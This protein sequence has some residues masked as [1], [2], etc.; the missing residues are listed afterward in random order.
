MP[1]YRI[2]V[3]NSDFKAE[4]ER[5]CSNIQAAAKHALKGALE[6]GSEQVLNGE[7]FFGAEVRIDDG[8]E[9]ALRFLVTVGSSPLQ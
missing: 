7:T 6:I 9:T 2:H 3:V 1:T 4:E 8:N 5:D